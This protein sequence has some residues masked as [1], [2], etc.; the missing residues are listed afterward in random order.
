MLKHF[1]EDSKKNENN[2][3][4]RAD[5]K[6]DVEE[7]TNK[8]N[9]DVIE[10]KLYKRRWFVI[11]LFSA[12]AVLVRMLMNSIGVI[13]N[14]YKAYFGLSYYVIDWFTLIQR[15]AMVI[16]AIMLALL[17]FNL[18][19]G[20]R[21]LFIIMSSC[22]LASCTLS[23]IASA[24][25]HFYGLI[26]VSQF[27][28]GF[29]AQASNAIIGSLASNWF[30]E[31]QTGFAMS[32][33]GMALSVGCSLSFLVTSLTFDSFP[34]LSN[35]STSLNT[36]NNSNNTEWKTWNNDTLTKFLI[37]YGTLCCVSAVVL[38]AV[39]ILV[40]DKPPKPPT[41]AQALRRRQEKSGNIRDVTKNIT[42]FC[43]ESKSLFQTKLFIQSVIILSVIFSC[44]SLQSLIMGENFRGVFADHGRHL[45]ANALAGFV[46]V[47]YEVGCF[48]GN[49]ISGKI[50][51]YFKKH[52]VIL[53]VDLVLCM[54]CLVGLTFARYYVNIPATFALNT[55]LGITT[56]SCFVPVSDMLLEH[57]YP[58]NPAF[59]MSLLAGFCYLV[60]ILCGEAS[61]LLL[62][63][64]TGTA[65][66]IFMG[67]L[68]FSCIVISLFLQPV[69]RRQ[70]TSNQKP[71]AESQALLPKNN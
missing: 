25:P 29:G 69:Y 62:N 16:S 37:F 33:E 55:L 31:E 71:N 63:Y 24:C 22:T 42:H 65:V 23:F 40:A 3:R 54:F 18:I 48:F 5:S 19:I 57:T 14:V 32:F 58:R 70:L 47:L 59:V 46:L 35:T 11:A 21:K 44:N 1:S 41:I 15:P 38:I 4:I 66:F 6:H 36:I 7:T 56:C 64:F 68:V 49:F 34:I 12:Q 45:Q 8:E 10:T 67:I 50:V 27:A 53:L 17:S 9:C 13:N 52:K 60:T 43:K 61:R 30:P 20:F 28:A 51:D 2:S 39:G 26:L